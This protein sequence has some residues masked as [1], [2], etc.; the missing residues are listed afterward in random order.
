MQ[1]SLEAEGRALMSDKT[2]TQPN[3]RK[4]DH[5][6]N[7]F[8]FKCYKK[9]KWTKNKKKKTHTHKSV[10]VS[11]VEWERTWKSVNVIDLI[12]KS[13]QI[14]NEA[15]WSLI[16]AEYGMFPINF[17][18]FLLFTF[19]LNKRF[20]MVMKI[21]VR[22]LWLWSP[23]TIVWL[24]SNDIWAKFRT[25]LTLTAKCL[26]HK[27]TSAKVPHELRFPYICITSLHCEAAGYRY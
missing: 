3:S 10:I 1:I 22:Q 23:F 19:F 14:G 9:R 26:L 4:G 21:G 6:E 16:C 11:C 12:V 17:N 7:L 20:C 15:L 13:P 8:W 2:S 25:R 24:I 5:Q 18:F 27:V